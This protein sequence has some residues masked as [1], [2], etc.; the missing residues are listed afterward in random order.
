MSKR[1]FIVFGALGLF[2]AAIPAS[3][4]PSNALTATFTIHFPQGHPASNA[5]CDPD[6]FC[7][8]GTVAGYGAATITI[9]DETFDEIADSPCFAVT[10]VEEIDLLDATGSLVLQSAGTFCRPGGSGDSNAGPSSYGSPGRWN[11]L[12]TIVGAESTGIF[13]RAS[14]GGAE[15]MSAN[16]GVGVWHLNGT[17]IPGT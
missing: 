15:T 17:V 1:L 14:G 3:A 7:G 16:G 9:L 10:R 12:F 11:L 2:L 6:T 4:S 8:V 5:P 13:D